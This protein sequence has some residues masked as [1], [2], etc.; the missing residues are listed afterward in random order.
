MDQKRLND[1]HIFR[2]LLQSDDGIIAHI[3]DSGPETMT[4]ETT[5]GLTD[6]LI[7]RLKHQPEHIVFSERSRIAR[8][9][10]QIKSAAASDD[11]LSGD[12]ITLTLV[13]SSV[14]PGY[15]DLDELRDFFTLGMPV[16]RLVFCDPE[17]L[18]SSDEVGITMYP[19]INFPFSTSKYNFSLSNLLSV[20]HNTTLYPLL[21]ATSSTC[22]ISRIKNGFM[23]WGH[24]NPIVLE[25]FNFKYQVSSIQH[26][27]SENP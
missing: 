18:L 9:G 19:S 11:A 10:V 23:M 22:R 17:A 1:N 6:P 5:F 8:L 2:G 7:D 27:V 4:F 16:G 13:A 14:I 20:I 3:V 24:I 15:P 26:R 12:T 21:Y 25:L